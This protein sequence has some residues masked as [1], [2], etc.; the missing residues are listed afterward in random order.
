MYQ[1]MAH[2]NDNPSSFYKLKVPQQ[3]PHFSVHPGEE[4]LKYH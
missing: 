3:M 4:L 1:F 2:P